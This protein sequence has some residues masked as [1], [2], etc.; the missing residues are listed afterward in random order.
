VINHNNYELI[1]K[2]GVTRFGTG[3]ITLEPIVWELNPLIHHKKIHFRFGAEIGGDRHDE[4]K[5]NGAD[6]LLQTH[7]NTNFTVTMSRD[8]QS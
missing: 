6:Y 3:S 8:T 2:I 1:K 5:T 4:M 7:K